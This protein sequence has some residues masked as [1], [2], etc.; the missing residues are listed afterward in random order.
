MKFIARHLNL[1]GLCLL[2]GFTAAA[3]GLYFDVP[4]A[5]RNNPAQAATAA[6]EQVEKPAGCCAGK[7]KPESTP[8][9]ALA[10]TA[11][12]HLA[13]RA[14]SGCGAGGSGCSHH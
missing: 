9:P 8:A 3:A 7:A 14:D 10:S 4:Q 13:A 11:C 6:R 2:A 5:L 1:I 12:P